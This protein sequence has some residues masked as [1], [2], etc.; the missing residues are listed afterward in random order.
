MTAAPSERQACNSL[1]LEHQQMEQLLGLLKQELSQLNSTRNTTPVLA[2]MSQIEQ[3][4]N[5][6]FACEE[7]VLFAAVSPY[8]PM[9]LM[10]VEHE[11]LVAT[12]TELLGLLDGEAAT[13]AETITQI[14]DKGHQFVSDMLD[15]IGREDAGIFPTCEKA[16]SPSEKEQVIQGMA[17]I[18]AESRER[19]TPAITRPDKTF[20]VYPLDLLSVPQRAL[21]SERV[22]E[23]GESEAKHLTI[24]AG[25]SLTSHWI[26]QQALL[27]CL[28]GEGDF[29]ANEQTKPLTPG[30]TIVMSPQLQHAIV[31]TADC[32]LLFLIQ[33]AGQ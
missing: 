26:P 21:M 22:F 3:E 30:T 20:Q 7:Q 15:H 8:H 24:R 27:I 11:E 2:L 4:I 1:T 29:V 6:H 13:T 16:L 31:A 12:S 9:V 10:E 33:K 23:T 28:R 14:Q 17:T 19:P 25:D 18:R 5:T 32:H